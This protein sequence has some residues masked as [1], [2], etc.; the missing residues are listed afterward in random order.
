MPTINAP[1]ESVRCL[2]C[3]GSPVDAN[4]FGALTAGFLTDAA[5]NAPDVSVGEHEA[6]VSFA[7]QLKSIPAVATWHTLHK[8][9]R[10]PKKQA[11]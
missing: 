2:G 1:P 7:L 9:H 3:R 4:E 8:T 6:V 5:A 11:Q 10:I